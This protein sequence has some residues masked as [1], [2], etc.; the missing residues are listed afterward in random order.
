M[1]TIKYLF[2]FMF[3]LFLPCAFVSCLILDFDT[4]VNF[5]ALIARIKD[6]IQ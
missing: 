6:S 2:G 5:L 4:L 3:H 1:I